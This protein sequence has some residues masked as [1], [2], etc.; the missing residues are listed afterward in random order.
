M[1]ICQKSVQVGECVEDAKCRKG[2]GL[3]EMI[4]MM[5][6]RMTFVGWWVDITRRIEANARIDKPSLN[7]CGRKIGAISKGII[8][9]LVAP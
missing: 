2:N 7:L 6:I 3:G 5:R 1:E 9:E 4:E 8:Q